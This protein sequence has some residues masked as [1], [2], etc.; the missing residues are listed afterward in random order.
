MSTLLYLDLNEPLHTLLPI[1]LPLFFTGDGTLTHHPT[2]V[3]W[4]GG[5]GEWGQALQF[6]LHSIQKNLLRT[7]EPTRD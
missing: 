6:V 5:N 2:G 1:L 4:G 3:G 7:A